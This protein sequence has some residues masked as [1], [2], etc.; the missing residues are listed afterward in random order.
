MDILLCSQSHA[1][2]RVAYLKEKP[3]RAVV[4]VQPK[5]DNGKGK[6]GGGNKYKGSDGTQRTHSDMPMLTGLDANTGKYVPYGASV[7][8]MYIG[9][10]VIRLTL[11]VPN[12]C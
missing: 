6:D 2:S 9:A 3:K 5:K 11:V 12:K 4:V 1:S 10:G 7:A 8:D